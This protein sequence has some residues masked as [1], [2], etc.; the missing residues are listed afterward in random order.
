MA[1]LLVEEDVM[2]SNS[3]QSGFPYQLSHPVLSL[4]GWTTRCSLRR[5]FFP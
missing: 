3:K 4:Q 1:F 5:L 2:M